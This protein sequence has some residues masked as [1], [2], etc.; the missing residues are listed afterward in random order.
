MFTGI[1]EEIGTIAGASS[2]KLAVSANLV[3]ENAKLG[4]SMAVNGVCLTVSD[5]SA[6]GFSVDIMPETLRRTNLGR[7]HYGDPV[8]L[9]RAM[10]ADGRFGGHFVQG[11]VDG[12]GKVLSMVPEEE[13]V[14]ARISLPRELTPYVVLKGFI[15]VDGISLTIIDCDDISFSVSLVAYTRKHTT[16]GTK[17]HG[18]I[19]NLEVDIIAKYVERLRHSDARG[20]TMEFLEERGFLKVR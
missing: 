14:V 5:L 11:H 15:A 19:V 12:I 8:N 1:V 3:L 7:L 13:A 18:D 2:G 6:G 4:D 20:V 9:E 16:L 10:P 17:K